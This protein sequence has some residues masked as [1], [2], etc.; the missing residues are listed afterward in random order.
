[1]IKNVLGSVGFYQFHPFSC[2]S[3]AYHDH[4]F[5]SNIKLKYNAHVYLWRTMYTTVHSGNLAG[6][7]SNGSTCSVNQNSIAR[8]SFPAIKC[9]QFIKCVKI[10]F[11]YKFK[12]TL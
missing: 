1:M 8:F 12:C 4:T 6:G 2:S 5:N 3:S 10:K 7:Q 11:S 9:D